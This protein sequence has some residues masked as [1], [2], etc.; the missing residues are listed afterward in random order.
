MAEL[1]VFLS[2]ETIYHAKPQ[3]RWDDEREIDQLRTNI[4]C[5]NCPEDIA[6]GVPSDSEYG[7]A[8]AMWGDYP[9]KVPLLDEY[10]WQEPF[11]CEYMKRIYTNEEG[12]VVI[13]CTYPE[14]ASNNWK[15]ITDDE[16]QSQ[17][18]Q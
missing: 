4:S 8:C 6:N 2:M 16:V 12:Y 17:K 13:E 10:I 7:L 5:D 9:R 3:E 14:E 18:E 1:K 11:V 15:G